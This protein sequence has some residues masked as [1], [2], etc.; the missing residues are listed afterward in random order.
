MIYRIGDFHHKSECPILKRLLGDLL[1]YQMLVA[2][3]TRVHLN[4]KHVQVSLGT[5]QACFEFLRHWEPAN[6]NTSLQVTSMTDQALL[7]F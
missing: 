6:T 5:W 1:V 2:P 7:V 4:S 3:A